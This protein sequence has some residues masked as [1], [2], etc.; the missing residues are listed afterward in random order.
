MV[1]DSISHLKP[2][3]SSKILEELSSLYARLGESMPIDL[4]IQRYAAFGDWNP[5]VKK[6]AICSACRNYAAIDHRGNVASCQMGLSRAKESILQ[7]SF[8]SVFSRLQK[9]EENLYLIMPNAKSGSCSKCYWR[10]ACAG[11]CPEHTRIVKAT[12]NASSPW[13]EL[14]S[15]LLPAYLRAIAIQ[16]KR[17][18]EA[19][20]SPK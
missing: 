10:F 17:R 18:V 6:E 19:C 12:T 3:L 8:A 4:P 15:G 7:D 20:A 2:G 5:A 1:R 13:C 9:A 16:S 11:G 14:Y